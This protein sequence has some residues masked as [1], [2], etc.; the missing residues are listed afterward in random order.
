LTLYL[1]TSLLVAA[2]TDEVD[3]RRVQVW[4]DKQEPGVLVISDWVVAEFSSALSIKVRG[5][6]LTAI[7]RSAALGKFATLAAETFIILSVSSLQFRVAARFADQYA[8]G[9]RAGDAL[10]LAICADHGATLC[11]LDRMLHKAGPALG[12]KT[13]AL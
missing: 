7:N 1:D 12:V 4:L 10:H 13:I 2:L 3:T 5:R 9:L 6:Q 8:L 11:T